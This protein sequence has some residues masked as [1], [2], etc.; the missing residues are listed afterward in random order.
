MGI[1]ASG[2]PALSRCFTQS[3]IVVGS[4]QA[5]AT[6]LRNTK[7]KGL[8]YQELPLFS[9]KLELFRNPKVVNGPA[10]NLIDLQVGKPFPA[11]GTNSGQKS[12]F[13]LRFQASP[14]QTIRGLVLLWAQMREGLRDPAKAGP[15]TVGSTYVW[16]KFPKN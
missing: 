5:P 6:I 11:L 14:S 9:A 7:Q 12:I 1:K 16:E 4:N 13:S 8:P 3:A 15:F 2:T 10:V